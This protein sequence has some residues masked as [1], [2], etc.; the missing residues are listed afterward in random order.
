MSRIRAHR[1][2]LKESQMTR[3]EP[4]DFFVMSTIS[5][6]LAGLMPIMQSLWLFLQILEVYRIKFGVR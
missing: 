6:L 4:F 5:F 3:N 1:G 2:Y